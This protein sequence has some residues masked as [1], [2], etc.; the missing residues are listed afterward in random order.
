M[1]IIEESKKKLFEH[2]NKRPR[3]HLDDKVRPSDCSNFLRLLPHGT[4]FAFLLYVYFEGLMISAYS[5]AFQVLDDERYLAAG[6]IYIDNNN[7]ES[8]ESSFI[9]QGET[10]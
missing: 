5:R 10:L 8:Q 6:I 3:P 9:Y 1:K 2:R 7:Q 4:V